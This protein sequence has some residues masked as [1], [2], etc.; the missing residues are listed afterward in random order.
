MNNNL[1][2]RYYDIDY[3]ILSSLEKYASNT[4]IKNLID[5]K[6][7]SYSNLKRIKNRMENGELESLGGQYFKNW[8]DTKLG[9]E[10]DNIS[11][12]QDI[13]QDNG[14]ENS[15]LKKHTKRSDI[16]PSERHRK[17]SERHD[18]WDDNSSLR[19]EQRVIEELKIINQ[20][21]KKII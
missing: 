20:L 15:H 11:T 9:N 3:S 7:I 13:K 10:R 16:R 14:I 18:T 12:S 6:K 4:T 5:T 2:G 1:Y 8:I 17:S 21:M 19:L